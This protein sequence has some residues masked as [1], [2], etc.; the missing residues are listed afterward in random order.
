[1]QNN[2]KMEWFPIYHETGVEDTDIVVNVWNLLGTIPL[3][4]DEEAEKEFCARVA[5]QFRSTGGAPSEKASRIPG[6]WDREHL[7]YQANYVE[8]DYDEI[9]LEREEKEE[10]EEEQTYEMSLVPLLLK[11]PNHLTH[12]HLIAAK[13]I[14][15]REENVKVPNP[16][17]PPKAFL[18]NLNGNGDFNK[19]EIVRLVKKYPTLVEFARDVVAPIGMEIL[20]QHPKI[21]E[22]FK[23]YGMLFPKIY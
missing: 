8:D 23:R 18:I 22:L 11:Y 20:K 7:T 17:G 13:L 4:W 10:E 2:K 16:R 19:L 1:M 5:W 3:K 6:I 9:W 12:N 15:C 14:R 21:G